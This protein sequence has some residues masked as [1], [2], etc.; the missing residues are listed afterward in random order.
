MKINGSLHEYIQN[1][2]MLRNLIRYQTSIRC[3]SESVA[4][5]S[6]FVASYLL[7]LHQ[8]YNFNLEK[9]LKIALLHDFSET[10]ISD[11]PHPVKTQVVGL[12]ELLK[13]SEYKVNSK[14]ISEEFANWLE[15]FNNCSTAEGFVVSLADVISVLTYSVREISLGNE[16][17][18][19]KVMAS[20]KDRYYKIIESGE[21]YLKDGCSSRYIIEEIENIGNIYEE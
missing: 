10:K 11:I 6:F 18:F 19:S 7:K 9:A 20:T 15:E 13:E 8:Y 5:H 1:I 2:D 3:S 12:S 17:F 14:Y 21:R 16:K 4:E